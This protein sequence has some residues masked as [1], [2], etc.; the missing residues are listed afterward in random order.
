[1]LHLHIC[2]GNE[3]SDLK[4][5]KQEKEKEREREFQVNGEN[6]KELLLSKVKRSRKSNVLSHM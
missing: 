4:K 6:W 3:I 1:M 2:A 5:I